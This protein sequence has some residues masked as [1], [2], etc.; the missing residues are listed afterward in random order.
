MKVH[1]QNDQHPARLASPTIY[2]IISNEGKEELARPGISLGWSGFAAGLGI[3]FSLLAQGYL[4]DGG[5]HDLI[6]KAG[7]IFGFLIV[8]MSRLQLFTENTITVILPILEQKTAKSVQKTARLWGIVFAT[9]LLGTFAVAASVAWFHLGGGEYADILRG[10][11]MHA[12]DKS[13]WEVFF[14]G[15]PAGFLIAAMVWM[16]PS[17]DKQKF[18]VISAMIY[19]IALGDFSH[20]VVGSCEA[21]LVMLTGDITALHAAGY[22][23]AAGLGNI[24]G[25]AGLFALLAYGQVHQE[26]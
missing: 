11:S 18:F 4:A 3:S 16:M 23:F 24:I 13:L 8:V 26:I 6:I 5:A 12:V 17:A 25:G 10:I 19:L 9:N 21:F 2:E 1:Q 7:Y 22:I 20:V 15:I 14:M